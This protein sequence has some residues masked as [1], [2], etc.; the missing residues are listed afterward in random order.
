MYL[1]YFEQIVAQTIV[2]LVGPLNWCLPFWDYSDTTN[3]DALA[4]PPG[5]YKPE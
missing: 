5:I 3:P 4:I 1:A 2:D